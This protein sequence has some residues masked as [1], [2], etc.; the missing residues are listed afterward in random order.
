MLLSE[1]EE[2]IPLFCANDRLLKQWFPRTE[3][4][5]V[6]G[7]NHFIQF[8]KPAETARAIEPFLKRHSAG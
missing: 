7:V 3:E 8:L 6:S 1:G 4:R 5:I 2:T